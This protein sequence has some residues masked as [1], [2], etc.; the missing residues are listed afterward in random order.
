MK[1][2]AAVDGAII[3]LPSDKDSLRNFTTLEEISDVPLELF[4]GPSGNDSNDG[5]SRD[6]P[7]QTLSKA[8]QQAIQRGAA[9]KGGSIIKGRYVWK[10][11]GG[12]V[13]GLIGPSSDN[14]F[15]IK[16]DDTIREGEVLLDGS[17]ILP[18]MSQWNDNNEGELCTTLDFHPSEEVKE[19]WFTGLRHGGSITGGKAILGI[20][21]QH[22]N[23]LGGD[24]DSSKAWPVPSKPQ[25]RDYPLEGSVWDKS[26]RLGN[27]NGGPTLG[28]LDADATVLSPPPKCFIPEY[29]LAGD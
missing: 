13:D 25:G 27:N 6:S 12:L 18:P 23:V 20:H 15:V 2:V 14:P 7:F 3:A 9:Q 29:S 5:T 26:A 11:G 1:Q 28:L 16:A 4:V 19:L 22:P 24:R 10:E 8:A 21:A 17:N